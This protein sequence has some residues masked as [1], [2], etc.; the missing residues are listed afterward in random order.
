MGK[1][2]GSIDEGEKAGGYHTTVFDGSHLIAGI[3][4]IKFIGDSSIWSARLIK[5]K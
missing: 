4:I 3:Y 5:I 1:E 2:V